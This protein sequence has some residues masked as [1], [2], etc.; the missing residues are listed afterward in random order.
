MAKCVN[1]NTAEY[2]ALKNVFG[3]N[4]KTDNV[5]DSYQQLNKTENFP[6]ILEAQNHIKERQVAMSLKKNDFAKSLEQNLLELPYISR[7]QGQIMINNTERITDYNRVSSKSIASKNKLKLQTQLLTWNIPYGPQEAVN[8]VETPNKYKVVIQPNLFS[9]KDV[10]PESRGN[11]QV[12]IKNILTH[13]NMLFPQVTFDIM[14]MSEAKKIYNSLPA[15]VRGDVKV[16]DINS[17]YYNGKAIL[18]QEKITDDIAI[19]EMLHPFIDSLFVE[20]KELFNGLVAEAQK[21]FPELAQQIKAT[22]SADKGF[23]EVHRSLELVTQAL[24]RHF[25]KQ[26]TEEA[27][28]SFVKKVAEFIQWFA[29]IINDL[30]KFLS[31][32]NIQFKTSDIKT[33]TT[34]SDIAKLLNSTDITFK[35]NNKA[36]SKVRYSLKPEVKKVYDHA[37]ATSTTD[38]QRN[39]AAKLLNAAKMSNEKV[40]TLSAGKNSDFYDG[41]NFI[42]F[43]Q[44]EHRYFDVENGVEYLSA[45]TAIKGTFTNKE[46]RQLNL[47]VGNDFDALLNAVISDQLFE[48]VKLSVLKPEL[49]RKAFTDLQTHMESLMS[50]GSIAIPQVILF[51]EASQIAGTADVLLITPAGKIKILDLKTSKNFLKSDIDSYNRKH[52][53]ADDS[54]LKARGVTDELSTRVQHNL[55]INL[56]RRMLQNMGYEVSDAV[57]ATTTFHIKVDIVTDQNGKQFFNGSYDVEG[58]FKHDVTENERLVNE[59]I[60]ANEN[61]LEKE[62]IKA[63]QRSSPE[64][65]AFDDPEYFTEEDQAS[66][67]NEGPTEIEIYLK[68]LE[69]FSVGL[70]KRKDA[71]TKLKGGIT[72]S[73]SKD[74]AIELIN[75]TIS[76]IELAITQGPN[77]IKA[78]Y[79]RVIQQA[80][81]DVQTYTDYVLDP[82]NI[83]NPE[84]INYVLNF[85]RYSLS[86]NGLI[87]LKDVSSS[88]LSKTQANLVITLQKK[89]NRLKGTKLDP[90]LIDTAIFN[91]VKETVRNVSSANFTEENL[92]QILTQVRDITGVEYQTG[93]LATS[94]DTLLAVLDKI[95]K[96]KKQEFQDKVEFRETRIRVAASKLLKLDPSTK[97]NELFKYMV[98]LDAEGIPTGY[99]V[100]RLGEQ[101]YSKM[102]ELRDSLI[103]DDGNFMEYQPV[104][105]RENATS[106]DLKFNQELWKK[107]QEFADFW[108]AE[109][110]DANG[111]VVSGTYHEYTKAYRDIRA[112]YETAVILDSGSIIWKKKRGVSDKLW[113]NFKNNYGEYKETFFAEKINGIPTGAITPGTVWVPHR[114]YRVAKSTSS[115]GE[116]MT[117]PKYDAIMNPAQGD[118]LALARK[119]FY[120][121]YV[122]TMAELNAK[123][124]ENIQD[125]MLG[126]IPTIKGE[127]A[128]TM[129]EQGPLFTKMWAGIKR[130]GTDLITETGKF[131]RVVTNEAGEIEPSLPIYYT[132]NLAK[133]GDLLKIEKRIQDLEEKRKNKQISLKEFE[134]ENDR[135]IA[136]KSR[137]YNKPT[138]DQL[139]LDL[140]TSLMKYSIM[141]ENFEAM[142]SIEDTVNAFVKVIGDREYLNPNPKIGFF[143]KVA[144][145]VTDQVNKVVPIGKRKDAEEANIVKRVKKWTRMVYYDD[146]E[147][148]KNFLDK[149][150]NGL[151]Q[152]SSLAY[153]ATNPLGNI[154][155]LIMG[156]MTNSIELAGGRYFKRDAYMRMKAQ[157]NLDAIPALVKRTAY[158]AGKGKDG[159]YDPKKPMSKWEGMVN[160]FRMLDKSSDIRENLSEEKSWYNKAFDWTYLLNDSFEY[161]VQTQTG[162]AIL[163]SYTARDKGGNEVSLYNA[164]TWDAKNQEVVFDSNKYDVIIDRAGKELKY[165][166]KFRYQLRNTI[167]EVNKTMHGNYA[168]E[169]RMVMQSHN[170]GK[171]AAQFKKWVAPAIKARYRKEYFD[172]NLGWME[173]RYRSFW[174]FYSFAAKNINQLGNITEE[175]VKAQQEESMGE[176]YGHGEQKA[177]NKVLNAYR[178]LGEISLILITFAMKDVLAALFAG[179]DDDGEITKRLKNLSRYQAD[180]AYKELIAFIP[181]AGTSQAWEF[182]KNPLASTRT[183]GELGQALSTSMWTGVDYITS[184]EEEFMKNKDY[185]YQRGK[186]KG[187]LKL[188]KEWADVLPFINS[189]QRWQNLD[190]AR[191][192]YIK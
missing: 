122:E 81:K 47:D 9:T 134:V 18:I 141:A 167:R 142:S 160:H 1:R 119:E 21:A 13:F 137:L 38:A 113:R 26:Y 88:P 55:Q 180:R 50:D 179:D 123:L 186:R 15:K 103:D 46:E 135:L 57:N 85:E 189:Y 17:F 143:G 102:R 33:T 61:T 101:Y 109:K 42:I 27:P 75:E 176:D 174:S 139:E 25:N 23:S 79:T 154:N 130:K 190:Q 161:N 173:G 192:F 82:A 140:A 49:A 133:D 152:Y 70:A 136:E 126:R 131:R 181:I 78:E 65:N 150:T 12:K 187:Q 77:A 151:I 34:L 110:A 3:N 41:G 185:V 120:E 159:Y 125:K 168:Y 45:T 14:P 111:E 36:D 117:N 66:E 80:I 171:L 43:D 6:T 105:D 74:A 93:D 63:E 90:G 19:E 121:L 40:G 178:T 62:K 31:G 64:S 28:Q 2:K 53:L 149:V 72:L 169:D 37:I 124:P 30:H 112:Q 99:I 145:A 4:I 24:S 73:M 71:L 22:Y 20:N 69:D 165:D 48:S 8:I 94:R 51:D 44:G 175:Y 84:Y 115:K 10:L 157:Y 107:K 114:K 164:F 172:E 156:K 5:I 128:N 147:T 158:I 89:L 91:Y 100:Q 87:E 129:K 68:S 11:N 59:L 104:Y 35:F 32:K 39:I 182:I 76:S 16:S 191:E 184:P 127:I 52:P 97:P 163:D 98:E 166:D 155:N 177:K 144:G 83:G 108:K 58:I 106:E 183:M 60:P 29:N 96:F 170:I 138:A 56:Y 86:F 146:Q 132:G 118:T 188:R 116:V 92:D 148:T 67:N 153:V 95:Y 54:L 7:F 162:M